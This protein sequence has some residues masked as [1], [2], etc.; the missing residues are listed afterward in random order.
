MSTSLVHRN[1]SPYGLPSLTAV[2]DRLSLSLDDFPDLPGSH[3]R[4]DD[5]AM[6]LAD[7]LLAWSEADELRQIHVALDD[8]A[9]SELPGGLP[10]EWQHPSEPLF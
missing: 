7:Q 8:P 1:T 10:G 6:P 4:H 2:D 5:D 3:A 9:V